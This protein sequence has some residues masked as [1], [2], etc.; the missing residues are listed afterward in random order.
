MKCRSQA[1]PLFCHLKLFLMHFEIEKEMQ[2]IEGICILQIVAMKLFPKMVVRTH[3][4][5][6]INV[7]VKPRF[8]FEIFFGLG[9]SEKKGPNEFV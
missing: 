5:S 6:Y 2:H 3:G 1:P 4:T 9:Y 7:E 8:G